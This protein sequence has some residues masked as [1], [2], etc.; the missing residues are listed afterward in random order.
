MRTRTSHRG[1]R[2]SAHALRY[3]AV[4]LVFFVIASLAT[5]PLVGHLASCL[6][7]GTDSFSHYWNNWWVRQALRS[8][9]SPYYTDYLFYPYGVSLVYKNL[10]WLHILPWLAL[11]PLL[12]SVAAYNLVFLAHLAFCGLTAFVLGEE[13]TGDRR[14][15]FL[16][17]LIYQCWP[18][19]MTQPSHPNLISTGWMPLFV[20]F[21]RRVV[22]HGRPGD[23][24]LCGLALAMVGYTRWQLLIPAAVVGLAYLAL[25]YRTARQVWRSLRALAVAAAVVT[26]ALAPPILL[27]IREWQH[28]PAKLIIVEEEQNMQTDVLAYLTPPKAHPL[29]GHFTTP[30]YERYYARRGSRGAFSPYVGVVALT[31]AAIG[32]WTVR[33][34]GLPWVGIAV[35]LIALALGP[36]LYVNGQAHPSV[37][38]PYALLERLVVIRLLRVPDRFNMSLALPF[39]ALAAY[40]AARL[41]HNARHPTRLASLLGAAIAFEY[42]VIPMPLQGTRVSNWYEALAVEDDRAAVLNIPLDPYR[43]KP[44][45]F[46]Q[47]VHHHPILQGRVSRFPKGTFRYLEAQPWLREMWQRGDV[48]PRRPDVGRQMASLADDGVRYLIVHKETIGKDNWRRWS[49]Y[50][51]VEPRFQDRQIAVYATAPVAGQDFAPGA[52]LG[53]VRALPSTDCL[54]PGMTLGVDVAWGATTPPGVALAARLTLSGDRETMHGNPA[55]LIEGWPSDEWSAN[56]LGWGYYEL[57]IP[58]DAVTGTYTLTLN[59]LGAGGEPWGEPLTVGRVRV[60]ESPCAS[61]VP[62]GTRSANAVFGDVMRLLGYKLRQD[63]RTLT[64]TLY[65]R[66]ERRIKRDYKVF[67]HVFD[68]ASGVPVAQDDAMPLRWKYPTSLWPVAEVVT[69]V[70]TISLTD[71]PPGT[72]ELGVGVYDPGDGTRLR[73]EDGAGRECADGRLVLP[74]QVRLYPESEVSSTKN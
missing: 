42:L 57:T 62:A 51:I 34:R 38:M 10:A 18:Y 58:T 33:R 3:V 2:A 7:S 28:N 30:A 44:Y 54:K 9:R 46:A 71:V 8:G 36:V 70:I 68:P 16:A 61:P 11:R 59:L 12:G 5:W 47:T 65:W 23:G 69:D 31:L 43:S 74:E 14:A 6:P 50:L 21:L 73:A 25:S 52:D 27:F 26:V 72:Y 20:L 22:R 40:G 48:P 56:A 1:R 32:L 13:L 53:V 45:M 19:R 17:G 39:A 37:P 63:A 15:A 35:T 55:P 4:W 64:L 29:L 67:I 66:A 41:L 60:S 24:V 49:R